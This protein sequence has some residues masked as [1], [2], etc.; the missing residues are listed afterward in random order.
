VV[1]PLT[2]LNVLIGELIPKNIAL[3]DPLKIALIAAPWFAAFDRLMGPLVDVFE[4]STKRI[5]K[6]IPHRALSTD[7]LGPHFDLDSLSVTSQQYAMNLASVE[8]KRIKEIMLPWDQTSKVDATMS[9]AEIEALVISSGHTRIPVIHNDKVVGVLNTKE[10]IAYIHTGNDNWMGIVRDVQFFQSNTPAIAA[11][12]QLQARRRH[13]AVV[14]EGDQ[15][16]GIVTLE[17]IVEE[18]I[19]EIYDEDDDGT[20]RKILATAP[21]IRSMN[22]GSG[23]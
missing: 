17:D 2:V 23:R 7:G 21:H 15:S 18:V 11:L 22:P 9:V 4:W 5:L 8:K 10:F 12:K 3:R 16:V 13:M 6:L 19:G 14:I 20:I 1:A